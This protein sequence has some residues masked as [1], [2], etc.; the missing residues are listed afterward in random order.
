MIRRDEL[1][2]SEPVEYKISYKSNIECNNDLSLPMVD[3]S[4]QKR[5]TLRMNILWE[6]EKYESFEAHLK[7]Y[8]DSLKTSEQS[9]GAFDCYLS[10]M[11][12]AKF[13]ST[14]QEEKVMPFYQSSE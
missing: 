11:Q 3:E 5:E 7:N 14:L 12:V 2:I 1:G 6:P 8:Y 4:L 9:S 13:M 10:E